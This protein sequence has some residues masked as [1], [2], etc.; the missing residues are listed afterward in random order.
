MV[1]FEIKLKVGEQWI[2]IGEFN[3]L[4][5]KEIVASYVNDK[6]S[7]MVVAEDGKKKRE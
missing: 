2:S 1:M 3:K 4:Q 7:F 6:I 5:T